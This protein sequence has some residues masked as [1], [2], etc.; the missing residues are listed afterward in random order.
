MGSIARGSFELQ[1]R[2]QV[3][4]YEGEGTKLGRIT[5]DKQFSGDLVGSSVVYMLSALT[6]V[7]GSAG[8]V[9]I[10]RVSGSLAGL[11]GSFVLQHSGSMKRGQSSLQLS[12]VPDSADGELKGLSGSLAIDIVEGKHLYAFDYTIE[13]E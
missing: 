3:A 8:Y 4:L 1:R 10:E 13:S 7:K 12:V 5:F 6:D 11:K 2:E 9:A